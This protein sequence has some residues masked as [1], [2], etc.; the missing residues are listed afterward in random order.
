MDLKPV[1]CE[2]VDRN[3]MTQDLMAV[4]YERSIEPSCSI[5]LCNFLFFFLLLNIIN[6]H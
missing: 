3:Q 5:K 4:S 6:W 1:G 2:E